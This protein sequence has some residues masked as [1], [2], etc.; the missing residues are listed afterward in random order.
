[1]QNH[2]LIG[3]LPCVSSTGQLLGLSQQ[4][5]KGNR[6]EVGRRG[7]PSG[8]RNVRHSVLRAWLP[9]CTRENDLGGL[10]MRLVRPQRLVA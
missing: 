9:S 4:A 1:M 5:E 6:V 3:Y 10:Q 8:A 2:K 7:C